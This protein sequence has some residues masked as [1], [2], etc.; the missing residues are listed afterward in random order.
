[1][2]LGVY[3]DYKFLIQTQATN[4]DWLKDESH[5]R[6]TGVQTPDTERVSTRPPLTRKECLHTRAKGGR[7]KGEKGRKGENNRDLVCLKAL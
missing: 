6:P 3:I 2:R 7:R 5:I 1:M 4:A